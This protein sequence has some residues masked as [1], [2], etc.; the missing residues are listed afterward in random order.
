MW[1]KFFGAVAVTTLAT[2]VFVPPVNAQ[3]PAPPMSAGS[4]VGKL[5]R[6]DRSF[7]KDAGE[8]G[9]AGVALAKGS[10]VTGLSKHKR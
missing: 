1:L 7:V 5:D 2:V 9:L 8:T 6:G 10:M 3:T 4:G